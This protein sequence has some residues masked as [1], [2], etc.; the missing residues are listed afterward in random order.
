MRKSLSGKPPGL[1]GIKGLDRKKLKNI[2]IGTVLGVVVLLAIAVAALTVLNNGPTATPTPAPA[3]TPGPTATPAPTPAP[4]P[5]PTPVPSSGR[6]YNND[7]P[8]MLSA[9]YRGDT[10]Q[11]IVGITVPPGAPSVNV[12]NLSISIVCDGNSFDNAWTIKPKDWDIYS[13]D[14]ILRPEVN[15]APVIDT[16]ALGIPQDKPLTIKIMRN[17]D[18]YQQIAVAPTY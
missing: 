10:G 18:L 16:K 8:F 5:T 7:G 6:V 9:L 14:S 13:S 11:L 15:I 2:A 3:A 17:G 1:S 12:S 4:T